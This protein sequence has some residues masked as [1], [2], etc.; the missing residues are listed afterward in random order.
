MRIF[1][2]VPTVVGYIHCPRAQNSQDCL[3]NLSLT[4]YMAE[5]IKSN[6][7]SITH[8][9]DVHAVEFKKLREVL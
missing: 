3:Y 6:Q 5:R 8:V 7:Q 2:K 1:L 9:D 4:L